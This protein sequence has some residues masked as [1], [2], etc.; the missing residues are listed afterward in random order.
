MLLAEAQNRTARAFIDGY[1]EW[2]VEGLLRARAD[3]CVHEV[4][5]AALR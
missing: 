3:S 1:N 2:T 5:P 4:L